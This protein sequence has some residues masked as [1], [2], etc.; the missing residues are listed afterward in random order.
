[1]KKGTKTSGEKN[2]TKFD[3]KNNKNHAELKENH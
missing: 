3:D 1:V 2:W